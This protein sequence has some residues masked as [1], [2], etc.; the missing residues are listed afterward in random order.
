MRRLIYLAL[1][2]ALFAV[3]LVAPA[4]AQTNAPLAYTNIGGQ[5]VVTRPATDFRW[6]VTNPGEPLLPTVDLAWSQD[7][8]RLLFAV[9]TGGGY[10]LRVADVN[11]Q[12]VTEILT[13]SGPLAGGAW[14]A[15]GDVLVSDAAGLQQ[16]TPGGGAALRAQGA[17]A[18]L[19]SP[20]GTH[21]LARAGVGFIV[22]ATTTTGTLEH[23]FPGTNTNPHTREIS[24]WAAGV[25]AP[26][27]AYGSV[28]GDGTTAVILGHAAR[29]ES[30]P[31]PSGTGVPVTPL[32]WVP[33]QPVLLYRDASGVRAQDASCLI[34]GGCGAP[35]APVTLLPVNAQDVAVTDGGAVVYTLDGTRF[36]AG[37][38]CIAAGNCAG[39]ALA[40]GAAQPGTNAYTAG[41]T[42]AFTRAG[43]GVA[44]LVDVGCALGGGGDG[45][46]RG[47]GAVGVVVGLSPDGVTALAVNGD[48]LLAINGA[49]TPLGS[50]SV[51]LRT[52]WGG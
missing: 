44:Q 12:Q 2:L 32:T 25:G 4:A 22:G 15:S 43:D 5:L 50:A 23:G 41:N 21:V 17:S 11:S 36:A 35:P 9:T 33:G 3:V 14:T 28:G 51:D 16:V 38:A 29:P 37:G 18:P 47:G 30:F 52:A 40:L 27:V 13:G 19:V 49:V 48:Q 8:G 10:S 42:T 20:D 1:M 39:G 26:L 34:P 6:I 31:Q 45:C 46:V 7:G 24:V